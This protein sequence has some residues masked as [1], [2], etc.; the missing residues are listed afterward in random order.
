MKRAILLAGVAAAAR[1]CRAIA[2]ASSSTGAPCRQ[3]SSSTASRTQK[4]EYR[5][6]YIA[7]A[8]VDSFAAWLANEMKTEAAKNTPSRSTRSASKYGRMALASTS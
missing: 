5:V 1:R 3:A 8:Q 2:R 7:R 6:A 4:S